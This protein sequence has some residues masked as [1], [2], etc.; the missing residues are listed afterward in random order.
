MRMPRYR[1]RL[2]AALAVSLLAHLIASGGIDWVVPERVSV[3]PPIE[4]RLAGPA[5]EPPK[6]S[7]ER[8]QRASSEA[9]KR[10][11]SKPAPPAPRPAIEPSQPAVV[12][13]APVPAQVAA[14]PVPAEAPAPVAAAPAPQVQ[15]APSQAPD[16]L[17]GLPERFNIR[18][19]VQGNEG[20]FV[21]GQLTHVWRRSCALSPS[22]PP[23]GEPPPSGD[24]RDAVRLRRVCANERY[25]IVGVA[26]ATGVVALFYSGLLSQTSDGGITPQGLR[27]ENYW[28]QRGRKRFTA[29]FDW[30]R[31][32]AKLGDPYGSVGIRAG[33]Q[34]YLSVVYQ[35]ALFPR[36]PYGVVTLV[37]GKRFKE[38]IY[39]ELGTEVLELPFGRVQ[40]V[41]IRVGQGGE[42]DDIEL[43][44][45]AA[46]P[47]L[48][49]KITLT[50]NKGK[51]GVL[52]AEEIQGV[53]LPDP[54][55][56]PGS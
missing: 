12:A 17:A 2:L 33:T 48:P 28:M 26:E 37:N 25:S 36:E 47:H 16:P 9:A 55:G 21:L 45:R 5:P 49:V 53:L 39:R 50:D 10:P 44:L 22:S 3:S 38:Y 15:A 1:R 27:P 40:T 23:E 56:R 20:G 30:D 42:A 13:V 4:A 24:K 14:V 11:S 32:V 18:F 8:A 46:P 29:H 7:P 34:D 35:L 54:E 51:S 6:P 19:R 43:W 41:H 31:N 52:L